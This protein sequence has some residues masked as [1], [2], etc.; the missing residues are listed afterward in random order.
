MKGGVCYFLWDRDHD[1]PCVVENVSAGRVVSRATRRLDAADVFIRFNEALSI[2]E[3]VRARGEPT[4][5]RTISSGVPFGLRTNIRDFAPEKFRGAVRIYSEKS[6]GWVARARLTTN[7]AWID[8]WKVLV[9]EAYGAG[10]GFPHQILGV[11]IVPEKTSAC[12]QTYL[13]AGT[14]GSKREAENRAAYMKTRFFRFLV[15]L[16]KSTQHAPRDAYRFVP[17]LDMKTRWTDDALAR[18]YGFTK[19]ERDFI[20]SMITEMPS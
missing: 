17:D 18:R 19:A 2:L 20:A 4:I 12:T 6:K 3:K 7:R 1:G 14:F 5:A 9:S 10:E 8:R 15:S 16:R 11:P 13:V